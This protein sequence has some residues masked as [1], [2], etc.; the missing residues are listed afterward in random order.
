MT[1]L[2]FVFYALLCTLGLA[3]SIYSYLTVDPIYLVCVVVCAYGLGTALVAIREV[4][5]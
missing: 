1:L 5:R 2:A 3:A 4:T